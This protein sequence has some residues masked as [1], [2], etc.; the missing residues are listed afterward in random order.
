MKER[1][2]EHGP[3]EGVAANGRSIGTDPLAELGPILATVAQRDRESAELATER[4]RSRRGSWTSS[5]RGASTR[6]DRRCTPL[7]NVF[8]NSVA[9][10]SSKSTQ[11]ARR[12]SRNPG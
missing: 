7:F 10:G 9:T 8:S 5:L 6:C 11:G 4:P 2:D 1:V 12:A 3:A